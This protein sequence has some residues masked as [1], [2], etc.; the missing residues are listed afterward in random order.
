M[1]NILFFLFYCVL[2]FA[3]LYG[4]SVSQLKSFNPLLWDKEPHHPML[5]KLAI[6]YGIFVVVVFLVVFTNQPKKDKYDN[7]WK[8]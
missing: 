5:W 1:K 7:L 8:R 2:L 6:L 4:V 3:Y